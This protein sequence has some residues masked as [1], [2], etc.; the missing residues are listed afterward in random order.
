[1]AKASAKTTVLTIKELA[2]KMLPNMDAKLAYPMIF[3][4]VNLAV[5]LGLI[6]EA[7]K[8]AIPGQRGK[9]S[10]LYNVPESI[11]FN[12]TGE[13]KI[14]AEKPKRA[15]KS[16]EPA[17]DQPE[18]ESGIQPA[19]LPTDQSATNQPADQPEPEL[20]GMPEKAA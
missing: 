5:S 15:K 7:G 18:P 16:A 4:L 17:A 11:S 1:M 9:P 14:K 6:T 2:T 13:L 3:N 10:T 19:T 20:E 12:L 8:R